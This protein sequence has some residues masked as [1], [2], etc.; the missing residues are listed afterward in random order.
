MKNNLVYFGTLSFILIYLF[1]ESDKRNKK[2]SV[3]NFFEIIKLPLLVTCMVLLA[4]GKNGTKSSLNFG[5]Q[6]LLPI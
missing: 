1:Q 3:K 5:N 4:Y 6:K 2:K